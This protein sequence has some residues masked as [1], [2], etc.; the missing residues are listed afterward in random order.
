MTRFEIIEKIGSK[1]HSGNTETGEFS[2]VQALS[3][4]G[5]DIKDYQKGYSGAKHQLLDIR[6]KN[7][8]LVILVECKKD[9][10]SWMSYLICK[11]NGTNLHC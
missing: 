2:Y 7:E 4:R 9:K 10:L 1:Y 6:F 3:N 5:K 8:R 11:H